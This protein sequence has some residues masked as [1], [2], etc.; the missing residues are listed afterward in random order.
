MSMLLAKGYIMAVSNS[1]N[2]RYT[3]PIQKNLLT[4]ISPEELFDPA[5][6][7]TS[8]SSIKW[9]LYDASMKRPGAPYNSHRH[10]Q[11]KSSTFLSRI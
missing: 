6:Y 11:L 7:A 8:S 3:Y 9:N 5:Q 2:I 4:N 1:G 10:A